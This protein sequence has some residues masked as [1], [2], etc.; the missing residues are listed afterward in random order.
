MTAP[1]SKDASPEPQTPGKEPTTVK[2]DADSSTPTNKPAA[3]KTTPKSAPAAT[4]TRANSKKAAEPPTLLHDFLRGRP[5][6]A[7]L[8]AE[9]QRRQSVEAVK[10]ELRHEMRQGAVKKLQP[11]GGVRDRVKAWQKVNAKA[12][13]DADPDDAATE[14][15]DIAFSGEDF[16]SVTEEDR[17]RIKMRQTAKNNGLK[18]KPVL[19]PNPNKSDKRSDD[20]EDGRERSQSPPKKRVVSDDHWLPKTR[21]S[22]PRRASP[23]RVTARKVSPIRVAPIR[24]A[25]RKTSAKA[26][27][28]SPSGGTPLPKNFTL[29]TPNPNVNKKIKAWAEKVE[30]PDTR[31]PR[32]YRSSRSRDGSLRPEG[33]GSDGTSDRGYTSSQGTRRQS[34]RRKTPGSVDSGSI[35]VKPIRRKKPVDDVKSPSPDTAKR[36]DDGI[37]VTPMDSPK[38]TPATKNDDDGI[39]VT[40]M[41]SPKSAP[42]SRHDD[43]G[44]RVRPVDS[45][46]STPA[47]KNGDD[48]IRVRP[49]DSPRNTPAS[50]SRSVS[51]SALSSTLSAS[52]RTTRDRSKARPMSRYAETEEDIVV[53][54]ESTE[55][56]G[57]SRSTEVPRSR[58]VKKAHHD[59]IDVIEVHEDSD[60]A[61]DTPAKRKSSRSQPHTKGRQ[62][63]HYR[64]ISNT[65][66]DKSWIEENLT[67][68]DGTSRL[69]SELSSSIANKSIADIPGEIPFGHSAFSELDLSA[70]G[71]GLR[72]RPKRPKAEPKN[73]SLK[74]MPG[75]FK[76]VMEEGKKI[77]H[78]INHETPQRNTAANKPPSIEKWLNNTVDPFVDSPKTDSSPKEK[79]QQETK[80]TDDAEKSTKPVSETPTKAP[81]ET[82]IKA[83][84][85]KSAKPA[86]EKPA[87]EKPAKTEKEPSPEPPKQVARES[88]STKETH[89]TPRKASHDTR[90]ASS[91]HS[92]SKSDLTDRSSTPTKSKSSSPP[93]DKTPT[94][95]EEHDS[96]GLKRRRAVRTSA[97]PS[98]S[99]PRRPFFGLLKEAFQ[100]ESKEL[101][102]PPATYQSKEERRIDYYDDDYDDETEYRTVSGYD[103]S[104]LSSGYD[105]RYEETVSGSEISSSYLTEVTAPKMAGPRLRPPT[106]GN[107]E[108]STILSEENCSTLESDLSSG[109]SRTTVTQSTALTKESGLSKSR[110]QSSSL[111][112]RLT[113]HSDLVSVLSLPND[114]NIPETLTF[115]RS[116]PS[117]R[118]TRSS[119]VNVSTADL[120]R[121]FSDDEVLY[122]RELKTL[123]DGVIPVLLTHVVQDSNPKVFFDKNSASNYRSNGLSKSVVGMGVALEKIRSAHRKAPHTDLRRVAHWAHGVVPIYNSYLNAWRL[124]FHDLVV[125]LAPAE[126]V[127]EDEDSLLNAMP[128]DENGDIVNAEGERVDVGHLLKRP[129]I[130]I[131]T[132]VKL[133]S[134]LDSMMPSE[135]THELLHNFERLQEKSRRRHREETARMTDEDAINTDTTR[136]RDLRTLWAI[137]DTIIDA[138]RQ[139]SAKDMF[140]LDLAHSNGQRLECQVE[141]VHRDN[142]KQA[143]DQG[144]LLIRET[145][146]GGR[147]YL[148]FPPFPMALISARTGDGNF[149]M[150]IMVRGTHHEREWFEL[151]TLTSDSE[152]Q[153]LDWL[154][155][156]P[157]SPVPPRQPEP[158]IIDDDDEPRQRVDIPV[159]ARSIRRKRDVSP[160]IS[161]P[162]EERANTPRR[163][164]SWTYD[165]EILTPIRESPSPE[166][167]FYPSRE[168]TPTQEDYLAQEDSFAEE[169]DLDR[170][171]PLSESMRPDPLQ[172][173][174]KANVRE[175][176]APPPPIHR[177]FSTSTSPEQNAPTSSASPITPPVDLE[178]DAKLKRRNSSPLKHEYLPS[179]GSEGSEGSSGS[180]ESYTEESDYESSDDEIE[181]IDIPETEIGVSIKQGPRQQ[182]QH[183]YR[184]ESPELDAPNASYVAE[185]IVNESE[186]SLTPSNSAS[187]AGLHEQTQE[188]KVEEKPSQQFTA[189]ISRWSDRGTW[190]DIMESPCSIVVGP[191]LI[192]AF[193]STIPRNANDPPLLAM[194][195]T[196]V[197]LIRHSTAVDVEIRSSL[198]SHCQIYKSQ[199]GGVFRFRCSN[200]ADSL[201]LWR[202]VHHARLN[203]QKFIQLENEARFKSFGERQGPTDIDGNS[204]SRKKSWFGR[205]NS[206]RSSV[207]APAQSLDGAST[208]ASSSLSATSFLKRL[209]TGN[210]AFNLARSSVDKQSRP[211]SARNSFYASGES[212]ASGTPPRSPSIS[213]ENSARSVANLNSEN[214]RIRL[215][216]LVSA[217]KWEDYGNCILQIRRPPPGWHQALRANHGMEKRVTVTTIPKKDSE[218]PKI[219]LDAVLGSACFSPMGS[220][221]IVCGI[222]EEVKNGDGVVGIA[223]ATGPTGG[224]IKKW[225]FQCATVSE[226]SGVLRLV[227]EE[228]LRA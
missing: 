195:L 39:R 67:S 223:P 186:C 106:N 74:G 187:Q 115:S 59:E 51:P 42:A 2:K 183:S 22:P 7:R 198:Q 225:C 28:S 99:S 153:I 111:K 120:L 80:K 64:G 91:S 103:D 226:A 52:T 33:A 151:I 101:P 23:A 182:D 36:D 191:G 71:T 43:D 6:P 12:L 167:D 227:H 113:K 152:D 159:G 56:S 136:C 17:I 175:D 90:S 135:D 61:T 108:L 48:G 188:E 228:V 194:D 54:V 104:R 109:I 215:H 72:T 157:V 77:I 212:S 24:V 94:K 69:D 144:D 203:N 27:S 58:P 149:D 172:L 146:D 130:R 78:D 86:A 206:Y 211:G 19:G 178:A 55:L 221:G 105:T 208:N 154:D 112:R 5:S 31:P 129:L 224:N 155:I 53:T 41:D 107:H 76:K 18:T 21:K 96:G 147:T 116:R 63:G 30:I 201:G 114:K 37:R 110:S 85:D 202:A 148:L 88:V 14:P 207:R 132:L 81:A 35:R 70:D 222:W 139:V 25:S 193:V 68:V 73:T 219:L 180:D 216:L 169:E 199:G 62:K 98:K 84:T 171:H 214:I 141:L 205:K 145:G 174:N 102:R 217:T 127:P 156:L 209:T 168:K 95:S 40:P 166:N 142:Q 66:D 79:L 165:D 118:K 138:N 123:V 82:P 213:V 8:A 119:A 140:S 38:S 4:R 97:Q 181:S 133:V 204:S 11:P 89:K 100:G 170:S 50:K 158:S 137:D 210:M 122:M 44:I 3:G 124:G 9:R 163:E 197:V 60:S 32:S 83:A 218:K 121:E 134:C 176:G 192:E 92:K 49:M 34:L 179:E 75:V 162:R 177:T 143:G 29:N 125:N 10:A 57:S 128:R 87:A 150:V 16:Q 190:K 185:S 164:P 220:R 1:N 46:R 189:H 117:L 131:K 13:E 173:R 160:K 47:S 196:P 45:P 200:A 161:P 65:R 15:T 93:S 26:E 20:S 184:E 126:G